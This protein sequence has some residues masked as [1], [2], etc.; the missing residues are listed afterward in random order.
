MRHLNP[1]VIHHCVKSFPK[2]KELIVT[3][4]PH[5]RFTD[6]VEFRRKLKSWKEDPATKSTWFSQKG[7][8]QA[9]AIREFKDL[10]QPI[11]FYAEFGKNDDSFEIFFRETQ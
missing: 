8:T 10:Y 2:P 5:G 7:R 9:A 1:T 6:L 11:E 4:G 3:V